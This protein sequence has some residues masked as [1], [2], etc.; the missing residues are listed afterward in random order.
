[1]AVKK[2]LMSRCRTRSE[3]E[4]MRLDNY[5]PYQDKINRCAVLNADNIMLFY[6]S[7]YNGILLYIPFPVSQ[8]SRAL[9]TIHLSLY[10]DQLIY[11]SLLYHRDYL[12]F[13]IS[14]PDILTELHGPH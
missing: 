11:H 8:I 7:S 5:Y 12:I 4:T 1:M 10:K 13:Y 14:S 2:D 3:G 6:I 9:Y